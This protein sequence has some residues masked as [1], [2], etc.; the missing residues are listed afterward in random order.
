MSINPPA[1]ESSGTFPWPADF[2]RLDLDEV[3][4]TMSEA[5]RRVSSI[6]RPTWILAKRQTEGRGR[7][8]KPWLQ[9]EGNL[10][11]TL[12]YRPYATPAEAAKRSFL[13]ANALFEALSIYVDRSKLSLK[14]PNDVMLNRGKV[15]GILLESSGSGAYVD[16]L[17]VG[18]GVN[19]A[20]APTEVRGKFAG[21]KSCRRGR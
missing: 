15:A 20:S 9:T 18:I 17:S 11:A 5:R 12:I 8:G 13:A 21:G 14:W 2:A 3:D 7:R 10:V 6:D 19:L 4:S 16:W 1:E